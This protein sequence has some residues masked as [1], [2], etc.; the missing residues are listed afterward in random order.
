MS[1]KRLFGTA[2]AD[3]SKSPLES[4]KTP[5]SGEGPINLQITN[6][7]KPVSK[8]VSKIKSIRDKVVGVNTTKTY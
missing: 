7:V 8:T 2:Q 4:A 3:R 1:K 6:S 5:Y